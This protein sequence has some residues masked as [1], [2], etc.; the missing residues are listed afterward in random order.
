MIPVRN[1]YHMLSYAFRA[2]RKDR[3]RRLE[4]EAF[5]N[6]W[7]LLAAILVISIG[8]QVRR[9][10]SRSYI[11]HEEA[12]TT[13]RGR[14]DVPQSIRARSLMHSKVVC[15]FDEFSIDSEFNRIL[16]A[17]V[18]LLLTGHIS[19]ERRRE[20]RRVLACF[21]DV[22]P[23]SL[24]AVRWRRLRF[25]RGNQNYAL[26]MAV[27]EMAARGLLM[28]EAEGREQLQAF[29]DDQSMAHL[30]EKFI[31]EYY[32]R[33]WPE[34]K[35]AASEIDWQLDPASHEGAFPGFSE[36]TLPIMRTDV[37]LIGPGGDI[38]IIDAKYYGHTVVEHYGRRI[39][40]SGNL[41]QIFTYVKNKT[42]EVR[43]HESG[44]K[45]SGMLLY[46]KTDEKV[47]PNCKFSMT[48]ND[49][50]VT[51]LDLDQTFEKIRASLDQIAR[52]AFYPCESPA[53]AHAAPPQG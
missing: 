43:R 48:G 18:L 32:R 2:L 4:A 29:I 34:L 14:L 5:E 23:A 15:E 13:L 40:H 20:L 41:Y 42:E 46:A 51:T 39:L 38:L 9:G 37:T 45:V 7:D 22:R 36:S 21:E 1:I 26:L 10:L 27:C 11:P 30:Y 24:R 6:A 17:T 28:R 8:D 52:D 35:A 31:L 49:I 44:R 3:T 47:V 25:N 50:T 53:K 33:E 16:K 19:Q 12:L